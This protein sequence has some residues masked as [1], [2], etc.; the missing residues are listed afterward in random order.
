MDDRND[1]Q[2]S[3]RYNSYVRMQRNDKNIYKSSSHTVLM[4]LI[5]TH[6]DINTNEKKNDET[7][8]NFVEY[9]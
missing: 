5:Q 6:T 2:M 8:I 7:C 9:T 4:N 1:E 3:E